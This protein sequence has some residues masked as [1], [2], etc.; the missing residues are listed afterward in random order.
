MRLYSYL[1]KCNVSGVR[2]RQAR[3]A[4]K[5]SQEALA[6]KL[7]LLGL[8]ISQKSISRIETGERVVPDY[9]IKFFAKALR[10]SPIW[11]LDEEEK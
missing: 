2:I 4:A 1:G 10:I 3:E 7:Q 8:E 9:E 5:L 11:L 6:A